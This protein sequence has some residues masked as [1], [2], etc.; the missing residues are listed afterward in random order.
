MLKEMVLVKFLILKSI[1]VVASHILA[2]MR[3]CTG[4]Q[5]C[6]YTMGGCTRLSWA[7]LL[8]ESLLNHHGTVLHLVAVLNCP[9]L[10]WAGLLWLDCNARLY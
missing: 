4:L 5:L 8:W 1:L 3:D 9:G 10:P 7:L 6:S 2:A